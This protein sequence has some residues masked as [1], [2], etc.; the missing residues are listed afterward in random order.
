MKFTNKTISSIKP[1]SERFEVWEDNGKGFGLRVSPAGK[2]SWIYLYRY[3]GRAR[4]MTF[5]DYPAMGLADAHEKHATAKKDLSKGID[6]GEKDQAKKTAHR[7]AFTVNDLVDEYMK[8]YAKPEIKITWKEDLRC[9]KKDVLPVIGKKKAKDVE[10]LN[11]KRILNGIID[12]GSPAMA[13]R[14]YNVLTRLF[15]FG[16]DEGIL[17]T[18]PC[19]GRRLPTEKSPRTR[20]L[21]DA[22]IRVFW[23]GLN[24]TGMEMQHQLALKFLLATAQRRGEVVCA[25]WREFNLDTH[26]WEIPVERL[27]SR[28]KR[29][30]IVPHLVPLSGLAVSLL[31]QIKKH[32]EIRH[33]YSHPKLQAAILTRQQ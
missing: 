10:W 33:S 7:N 6:P 27:K 16:V 18:S 2:K 23:N 15:N 32:S 8:R 24:R 17:N 5:G 26:V 4:R 14:T 20:A 13:N 22:E 25:P 21:E 11:I 3:D 31:K 1:K 9:L 19:A 28:M 29:K 12:R 30:N